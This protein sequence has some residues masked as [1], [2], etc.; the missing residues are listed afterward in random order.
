[1]N[2]KI[3]FVALIFFSKMVVCSDAFHDDA[4]VVRGKAELI[5]M[6][7]ES[8]MLDFIFVRTKEAAVYAYR[9][10]EKTGEVPTFW[11]YFDSRNPFGVS[12][13]IYAQGEASFDGKFGPQYLL[14]TIQ[15][16]SGVENKPPSFAA[17]ITLGVWGDHFFLG[18][19]R[20]T[21]SNNSIETNDYVSEV[22][23]LGTVKKCRGFRILQERDCYLGIHVPDLRLRDCPVDGNDLETI[24]SIEFE[25]NYDSFVNLN[26]HGETSFSV[27]ETTITSADAKRVRKTIVSDLTYGGLDA[28]EELVNEFYDF[29]GTGKTLV[30]QSN[31]ELAIDKGIVMVAT[32]EGL[33]ER[34]T[35]LSYFNGQSFKFPFGRVAIICGFLV[36]TL[37]VFFWSKKSSNANA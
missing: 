29:L 36:L 33:D 13:E 15:E 12:V 19:D 23:V 8:T 1:M 14:N 35:A 11:L 20:E 2:F 7:E 5:S 37:F 17:N 28:A 34:I 9:A 22:E 21:S 31:V 24:E 26:E 18:L 4:C 30:S 6:D 27:T 25:L 3:V 32:D 10:A 16:S